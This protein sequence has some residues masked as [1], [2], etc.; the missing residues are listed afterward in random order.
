METQVEYEARQEKIKRVEY[1]IFGAST[2]QI[3]RPNRGEFGGLDWCACDSEK[4]LMEHKADGWW[5]EGGLWCANC[6]KW[7]ACE[8]DAHGDHRATE[9][10]VDYLVCK[11]HLRDAI[12][13]VASRELC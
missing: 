1:H 12:G 9:V 13:N 8:F 4:V 5:Q 11:E 6:G 3:P 2:G 7:I 10:R